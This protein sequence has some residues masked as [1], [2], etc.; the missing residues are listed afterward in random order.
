MSYHGL[1]IFVAGTEIS[2]HE[3]DGNEFNIS[4]REEPD[5]GKHNL[6]QCK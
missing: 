4:N 1:S 3:A 6:Q 5:S 2:G